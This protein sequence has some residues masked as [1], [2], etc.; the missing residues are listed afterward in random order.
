MIVYINDP[1]SSTRECLQL[2]N[3]FREVTGYKI[4]SK[5]LA[6]LLYT[7]NKWADEEIREATSFTI[8]TNN[9]ITC[10]NSNKTSKSPV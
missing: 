9:K 10:G 5:I 4:N 2:I 8:A 7:N 1:K 3:T 6:T